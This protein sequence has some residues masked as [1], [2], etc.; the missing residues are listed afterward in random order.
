MTGA[1]PV[2][3]L[4]SALVIVGR[5]S[6]KEIDFRSDADTYC[7]ARLSETVFIVVSMFTRSRQIA[8]LRGTLRRTGGGA[9]ALLS[10]ALLS[11]TD[12][13]SLRLSLRSDDRRAFTG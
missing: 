12:R 7:K 8:S 11:R 6:K 2:A 4:R 5:I 1:R 10:G 3:H 13:S 9:C